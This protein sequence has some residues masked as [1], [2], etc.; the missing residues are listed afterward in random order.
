[1]SKRTIRP[2]TEEDRARLLAPIVITH[3]GGKIHAGFSTSS[4]SKGRPTDDN[5][6]D[7]YA[8]R[9]DWADLDHLYDK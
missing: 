1:M 3:F 5:T 4:V 8:Q 2:Y 6:S 7:R 9:C